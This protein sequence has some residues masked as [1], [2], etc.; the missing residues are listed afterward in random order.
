[1]LVQQANWKTFHGGPLKEGPGA[2]FV[3]NERANVQK[4]IDKLG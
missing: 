2:N 1:M 4:S 3:K